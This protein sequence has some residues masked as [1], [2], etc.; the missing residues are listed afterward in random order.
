[1]HDLTFSRDGEQILAFATRE[2]C[3]LLWD[4]L[5]E[6]EVVVTVKKY[7][8]LKSRNANNYAWA[9]MEEIAK[10]LCRDKDSVYE[11]ML[12]LYGTGETYTDENGNE[13][14][15]LFALQE[16]IPPRLF[17][18]HYAQYDES[19]ID[20]KK[21]IHYR[22]IKGMSEYNTEEMNVLTEGI[23]SECKELNIE[24]ATPEQQ[25]LYKKD[26]KG[27]TP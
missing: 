22:A 27:V 24:T 9:L 16:G 8:K 17:A 11:E 4:N 23:V 26:W 15:S 3:R 25:S 14:K 18:R 5:H 10:V 19:W 1:M 13:C 12:R 2:D 20:G 6:A 7:R 21:Y